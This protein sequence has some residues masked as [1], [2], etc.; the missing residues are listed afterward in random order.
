MTPREISFEV[1][2]PGTP[3]QVW[4]AIATGP[5]IS[6]W[7]VQTEIAGAEITQ[8]HGNGFDQTSRIVA[9]ERPR[10]FAY[11][12]YF[13]P[14]PDVEPGVVATEFLVEARSGGTCVVG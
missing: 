6:G 8:H 7:F 13:Q 1:E 3:G 5:G 2:G 14:A 4:D 12:D 11:E 9:S 10:R